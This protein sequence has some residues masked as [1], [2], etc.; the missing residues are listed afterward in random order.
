MQWAALAAL[1]GAGQLW[2]AGFALYETST[3]SVAL[4]GATVGSPRGADTIYDNPAGMTALPGANIEAGVSFIN[5][6]MDIDITT[7]AGSKRFSP[8]DKWFP[9]PFAYYTHQLNDQFWAG[10]GIY[11]PYGLGVEHDM[12]DWPGRYNSVETLI[13]AFDFNPNV[14]YRVD[15]RLSLA[16]G[17]QVMYFDIKLTRALPTVPALLEIEGDSV[18]VG[19]NA[20]LA[21]R[22]LDDLTLGL[23]YR[24]AVKQSVEGDASVGPRSIGAEGDITLPASYTVGLNYTGV[25]KWNFG[26]IATFTE[27]SSYDELTMEFASPALLGTTSS[28]AVKDWHDVW[29]FGLGAEYQV[30]DK[31]ALQ[32]GYVFDTDPIPGAHADYLLPPGDRHI[33]SLGADYLLQGNWRV[34]VAVAYLMLKDVEIQARP[35]EGVFPTEFTNGDT[36]IVSFSLAKNF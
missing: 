23:V 35:A 28:T 32:G 2:G 21:Y 33:V 29:R 13:E 8:D 5:P 26:A 1:L 18:G 16:A 20:A 12:A 17:L 10:I 14:A 11:A 36:T 15:D 3:R 25:A 24:S 30:N 4:G 22:L 34:G 31:L 7:P 19:G 6:A 9:P 27:W